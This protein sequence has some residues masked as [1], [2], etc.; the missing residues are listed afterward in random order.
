[1]LQP[2]TGINGLV[3]LDKPIT[4]SSQFITVKTLITKIKSET[5]A[6][7]SISPSVSERKLDI[8]VEALPAK[9]VLTSVTQLLKLRWKLE[10]GVYYL[11]TDPKVIADSKA[12]QAKT[13]EKRLAETQRFQADIMMLKGLTRE[14]VSDRSETYKVEYDTLKSGK[15]SDLEAAREASRK[16]SLTYQLAQESI[17]PLVSVMS[18]NAD[19]WDELWSGRTVIGSSE[20]SLSSHKI[21]K[22]TQVMFNDTGKHETPVQVRYSFSYNS[23]THQIIIR[24]QTADS[25]S[26]EFNFSSSL[27]MN[28][29]NYDSSG[30]EPPPEDNWTEVQEDPAFAIELKSSII[31]PSHWFRNQRSLGDHL[32]WLHDQTKLNIIAESFRKPS[33]WTNLG[34]ILGPAKDWITEL[35][36]NEPAGVYYQNGILQIAQFDS[37]SKQQTEPPESAILVLEEA[38]KSRALHLRDYANYACNLTDDQLINSSVLSTQQMLTMDMLQGTALK[39]F[40]S[41]PTTAQQALIDGK[42]IAPPYNPTSQHYLDRLFSIYASSVSGEPSGNAAEVWNSDRMIPIAQQSVYTILTTQDYI[43]AGQ[44][45]A[46]S[47]NEII[48]LVPSYKLTATRFKFGLSEKNFISVSVMVPLNQSIASSDETKRKAPT[49]ADPKSNF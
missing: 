44:N 45:A 17:Y 2:D 21:D 42:Q 15:G 14:E 8:F 41:L 34:Q 13:V 33:T 47:K 24:N 22:F 40:G 18:R 6:P 29:S 35:R 16:Y 3:S 46:N 28:I 37:E 10:D 36:D 25:E 27:G 12:R 38:G 1:M 23:Y 30:S 26:N 5:S 19:L 43:I 20:H 48:E 39:F 4:I 9:Q 11:S 31:E 7:I 49:N 32:K